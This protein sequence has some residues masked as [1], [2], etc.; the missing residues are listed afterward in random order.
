MHTFPRRLITILLLASLWGS[1]QP[2]LAAPL[3]I[4]VGS[5]PLTLDWNMART[6]AESMVLMNI[7]EGLTAL[8]ESLQVKP[9]LAERWVV[10]PDGKTYTFHLKKALWLDGKPLRAQ[11][12]THSW[13]RL[14]SP[15]TGS[16]YKNYL[17]DVASYRAVSDAVFEVR[18]KRVVPYF[19]SLLTFWVTFP[20]RADQGSQ[21]ITLGPYRLKS[22]KKGKSLLFDINPTY[23]GSRP[24]VTAVET[25][26]EPDDQKALALLSDDMLDL[27]PDAS[28]LDAFKGSVAGQ[29]WG[30]R[31]F[32]HLAVHYLG[33]NHKSPF[34]AD[35]NLRLAIAKAINQEALVHTIN[36]KDTPAT[37]FIPVGLLG[38]EAKPAVPFNVTE[39]KS[40]LKA[41][42]AARK[43]SAGDVRLKL[44]ARK[45]RQYETAQLVAEALKRNLGISVSARA[46]DAAEYQSTLK[47]G[48][49][50]LFIGVWGADFPDPATFMDYMKSSAGLNFTNWKSDSFDKL[51]T[52]A[53]DTQ[54]AQERAE[55]YRIASRMMLTEHVALVPLYYPAIIV[56]A[57]QRVKDVFVDPLK[58]LFFSRLKMH[59]D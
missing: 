4:R 50:D 11:D 53:G 42:L 54:N 31:T 36:R 48:A 35:R 17:A 5:D 41:Y 19:P 10:S 52:N 39:A 13:D 16:P 58:Y 34:C 25:V 47:S 30:L 9:A 21:I 29:A 14:R 51:V 45:G 15:A 27:M 6:D 59:R 55:Y 24:S 26:V 28:A 2:G 1:A 57:G 46:L 37:S 40:A 20:R 23:H 49:E 18:L 7:M 12:F 33:F 22:W 3:R 56:L 38:Y 43:K 8:D 44:A 32:K